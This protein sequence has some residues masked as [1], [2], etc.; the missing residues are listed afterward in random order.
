VKLATPLESE[1][2][3]EPSRTLVALQSPAAALTVTF[4]GHVIAGGVLSTMNVALGP[5]AG[6]LLPAVS[7]AVPAAMEIPIVPSPV[8]FVMVI[9]RV[10]PEPDTRTVP[11]AVPVLFNV[12]FPTASVLELKRGSA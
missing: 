5:A 7:E 3:G 1:V 9:V 11:F 6:A 2:T 12:T 10:V 4:V 8:V